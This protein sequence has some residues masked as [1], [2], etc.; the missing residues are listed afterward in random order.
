MK[1]NSKQKQY[2]KTTRIFKLNHMKKI[3]I[4]LLF[5]VLSAC[6]NDRSDIQS[7]RAV[8]VDGHTVLQVN[9][10]FDRSIGC[11]YHIGDIV[12]VDEYNWIGGYGKPKGQYRLTYKLKENQ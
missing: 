10:R 11:I 8:S 9:D 6:N 2:I 5:A 4:I 1:P 3:I 12:T 7:F